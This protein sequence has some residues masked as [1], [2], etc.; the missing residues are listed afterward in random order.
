M[1]VLNYLPNEILLEIVKCL[2]DRKI[3][4]FD[5][6]GTKDLQHVRLVSKRLLNLATPLLFEN[7]VLDE[8]LLG[9][10][11]LT[12]I[13]QFMR[14]N[15]HLAWHVRRVQRKLSPLF[16]NAVDLATRYFTHIVFMGLDM[17]SIVESDNEVRLIQALTLRLVLDEKGNPIQYSV[18]MP[19]CCFVS[20]VA[21][22]RHQYQSIPRSSLPKVVHALTLPTAKPNVLPRYGCGP[23]EPNTC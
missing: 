22:C 10:E 2:C 19:D 15:P 6:V 20:E 5:T 14:R 18:L 7:M 17:D 8:K 21:L 12:G 3:H 11:D 9:D 16:T 4:H 1:T 13:S 23:P